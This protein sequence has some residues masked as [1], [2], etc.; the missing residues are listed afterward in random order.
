VRALQNRLIVFVN[1]IPDDLPVCAIE[2][3]G[4]CK[5]V[6]RGFSRG[7]VCVGGSVYIDVHAAGES[8]ERRMVLMVRGKRNGGYAAETREGESGKEIWR[9]LQHCY[10]HVW[11][12]KKRSERRYARRAGVMKR[13]KQEKPRL[14]KDGVCC[15]ANDQLLRTQPALVR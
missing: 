10:L 9:R 2:V 14:H 3:M 5:E 15:R 12:G 4:V 8:F 13:L 6:E 7:A 11:D 1:E